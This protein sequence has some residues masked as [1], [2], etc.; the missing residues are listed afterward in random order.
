MPQSKPDYKEDVQERVEAH[1][2][3]YHSLKARA[4][5]KRSVI[6]KSADFL[7]EI[8]GTMSFLI[9]NIVWFT[10]WIILNAKI[11]PGLKP[12][13]PFPF[14]FLTMAVSLEAIGLS[15]IVLISQNRAAHIEDLRQETD[16]QINV[17]SEEELTKV[18][19]LLKLLLEKSHINLDKDKELKHMLE[20]SNMEQMEEDLEQEMMPKPRHMGA[21]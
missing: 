21:E 15:I 4:D 10:V 13:D 6:E 16:L 14:G 18:L 2:A 12:F 19:E 7:T 11:I 1:R 5:A 17:Q 9:L 3:L 20:P 8:F